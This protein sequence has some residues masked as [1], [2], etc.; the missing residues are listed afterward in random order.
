MTAH[1]MAVV[2]ET[3][4]KWVRKNAIDLLLQ[5][6]PL[7]HSH[8]QQALETGRFEGRQTNGAR[9]GFNAYGP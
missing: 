6:A 1:L 8:L 4:E 9:L 3:G 7:G 5:I 2:E